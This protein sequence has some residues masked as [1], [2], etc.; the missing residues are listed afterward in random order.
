[1]HPV[2]QPSLT[3][4]FLLADLPQARVQVGRADARPAACAARNPPA[5]GAWRFREPMSNRNSHRLPRY[6]L[7]AA[8]GGRRDKGV[9]G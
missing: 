4:K 7:P 8:G 2:K 6:E 5:P 9:M 3:R 1:M